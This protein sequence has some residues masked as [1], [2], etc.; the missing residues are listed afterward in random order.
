VYVGPGGEPIK[1]GKHGT[2]KATKKSERTG[3]GDGKNPQPTDQVEVQDYD[4]D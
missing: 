4:D 1:A 2:N 3:G